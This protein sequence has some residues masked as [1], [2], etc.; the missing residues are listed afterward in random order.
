MELTGK[1]RRYLRGLGH[2]LRPVVTLGK[3][4]L[5]EGVTE[6][7]EANLR[8]HELIKVRL[9]PTCPV[10]KH[11]LADA[12]TGRLGATVVQKLGNTVL[13]YRPDAEAPAIHLPAGRGD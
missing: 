9:L 5:D 12:A 6:Q 13:L 7:L 1:Q 3:H 2:H 8:A 4:G 11:A 10:D